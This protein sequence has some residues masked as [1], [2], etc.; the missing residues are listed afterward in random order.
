MPKKRPVSG[1]LDATV[2]KAGLGFDG[3]LV[4]TLCDSG[5]SAKPPDGAARC[6]VS[7]SRVETAFRFAD[8]LCIGFC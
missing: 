2:D 5:S 1:S 8:F 6:V 7:A 4:R 3:C